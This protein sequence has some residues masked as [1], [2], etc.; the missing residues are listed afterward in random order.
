MKYVV[1]MG[2]GS[3]IYIS[4]LIKTGSGIQKLMGGGNTQTHRRHGNR[5]TLPRNVRKK[6]AS[7]NE[8]GAF[9]G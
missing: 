9:C 2:S 7:C 4:C 6:T 8:F 1:E 5:I 3:L